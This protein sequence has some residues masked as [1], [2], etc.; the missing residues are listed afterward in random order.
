[1]VAGHFDAN[2]DGNHVSCIDCHWALCP[3]ELYD[4]HCAK[5]FG[6]ENYVENNSLKAFV[7]EVT[8]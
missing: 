7:R 6:G 3:D 4:K 8:A 1:M 2:G 5:C